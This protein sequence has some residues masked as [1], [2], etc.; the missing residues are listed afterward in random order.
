[1]CERSGRR[2]RGIP[3]R[4]RA[5]I[6]DQVVE[7]AAWREDVA[8]RRRRIGRRKGGD[9]PLGERAALGE[10]AGG[11]L[12]GDLR[13][14]H[15]IE[16]EFRVRPGDSGRAVPRDEEEEIGLPQAARRAFER[17]RR[18]RAEGAR[19]LQ[20]CAV[21]QRLADQH[22]DARQEIFLPPRTEREA[23][24]IGIGAVADGAIEQRACGGESSMGGSQ[25]RCSP[26][27]ASGRIRWLHRTTPRERA[28]AF[29]H[30]QSD[31]DSAA[32]CVALLA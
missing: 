8:V 1:M 32:P 18:L 15:G 24:A 5:A 17:N 22:R 7:D 31:A 19:R 4:S 2:G 14:I 16:A 26:F 11:R 9:D 27:A 28:T 10:D 6:E 3:D 13:R 12:G 30:R 21:R 23:T 20:K 29:S 25:A